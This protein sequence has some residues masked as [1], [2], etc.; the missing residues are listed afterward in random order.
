MIVTNNLLNRRIISVKMAQKNVMNSFTR[1]EDNC[2]KAIFKNVEPEYTDQFEITLGDLLGNDGPIRLSKERYD[3]YYS[4]ATE[5]NL[6]WYTKAQ[7]R[8]LRNA[9]YAFH[10][11]KFKSKDLNDYFM[12]EGKYWWPEYKVNPDFSEDEFTEIEKENIQFI[13]R[14]EN[15]R[16]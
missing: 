14:E 7:L 10:G 13:L 1:I 12:E 6:F 4:S 5:E 9:I 16:K 8:I 3:F 11:Y 2:F 15:R